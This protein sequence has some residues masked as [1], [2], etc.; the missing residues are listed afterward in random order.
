MVSVRRAWNSSGEEVAMRR[1]SYAVLL[2]V[3]MVVVTP[4]FV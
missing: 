4:N 3:L 2:G 1:I